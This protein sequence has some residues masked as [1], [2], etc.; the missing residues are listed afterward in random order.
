MKFNSV[1]TTLAASAFLGSATFLGAQAESIGEAGG[2]YEIDPAHTHVVFTVNHLGFA[3]TVGQFGSVSGTFNFDPDNVGGSNVEVTIDPA[4]IDSNHEKRDEHLKGDD[5]FKSGEF[6]SIT[7]VS[8][9]IEKTGDNTATL[10]GDITMLG[11]TKPATLDVTFRNAGP[12][13]FRKEIFRTGWSATTTIKR[14]DF[15]MGYGLPLIG[16]EVQLDIQVEASRS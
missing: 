13:P 8:T 12:H 5:F 14:S 7:F 15:G 3:D 11:V 4:S 6:P 2:A 9:G 10:T 1:I 16:D